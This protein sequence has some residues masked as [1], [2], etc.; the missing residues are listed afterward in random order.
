M[1]NPSSSSTPAAE[2]AP[3]KRKRVGATLAS[4]FRRLGSR[5]RPV[6]AAA[7][8]PSGSPPS[9]ALPEKPADPPAA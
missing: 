2:K 1:T 4:R 7:S 6:G 9:A 3:V 8:Q 5:L